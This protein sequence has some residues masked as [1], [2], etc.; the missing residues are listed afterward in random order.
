MI[1]PVYLDYNAT[2]PMDPRVL[3]AM[4]PYFSEE[5]GNSVSA[6]HSYGWV[7]EKAVKKAREQVA[8]LLN[9][10]PHEIFFT[11]GATESNNWAI[12]GLID[13]LRSEDSTPLHFI[14]SPLEHSSVLSAL[15]AAE[16][17]KDI[18]V[19]WC[20][21]NTSGALD[22]NNLERMLKTKSQLMSFMWV[23]N[24]IGSINP[25][26]ALGELAQSQ[27][28]YLHSDATQ[29]IGKVVVDLKKAPVELL[30]FSGHKIYGPK[31]AGVLFVRGKNP[32]VRIKPLLF[33]GGHEGGQRSGT[34]NVP[35]IVGLGLAC[36]I[37]QKEFSQET[38]K[39]QALRNQLWGQIQSQ[40][41]TARLNG[42]QI[43]SRAI[44][45]LNITFCGYLVP[46]S[47][48]EI[49]ISRGSACHSGAASASPVL[50]GIGVSDGDADKTLRISW[51][52]WTTPEDIDRAVL[53]LKK[54]LKPLQAMPNDNS[55]RN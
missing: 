29:A 31:G 2:T 3:E 38:Q 23:N 17:R 36:E 37:V 50:K 42:P 46:P 53:V 43:D 32:K 39:L 33:G 55:L 25:I 6:A 54:N 52:R 27:Q 47:F 13:Q 45:S 12:R 34:L 40:F 24:E 16:Q 20:A 14:S 35:A 41:P 8:S 10:D 26:Q 18:A 4:L 22:I 21:S 49:A 48:A 15:R 1:K 9:C 51:G 11:A 7:A 28:C 30:S 19:S 44:N 5:F